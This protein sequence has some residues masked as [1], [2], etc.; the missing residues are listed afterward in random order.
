MKSP[1]FSLSRLG[2]TVRLLLGALAA[3]TVTLVVFE[4]TAQILALS[5]NI[6]TRRGGYRLN[7]GLLGTCLTMVGALLVFVGVLASPFL[8]NQTEEPQWL[9]YVYAFPLLA[10]G[11]LLLM[12]WFAVCGATGLRW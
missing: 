11:F 4:V 9:L 7:V 12:H 5:E 3:V 6:L 8:R 2:I 1:P 10:A